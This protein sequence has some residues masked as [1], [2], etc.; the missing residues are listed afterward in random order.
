MSAHGFQLEEIH[1]QRP[2]EREYSNALDPQLIHFEWLHRD[3]PRPRDD[4]LPNGLCWR[5]TAAEEQY[6]NGT[7]TRSHAHSSEFR[8]TSRYLHGHPRSGVATLKRCMPLDFCV[9]AGMP[10][11]R[12]TPRGCLP[13]KRLS[14][15]N[16]DNGVPS[17]GSGAQP[18]EL[19]RACGSANRGSA[20]CVCPSRSA[21]PRRQEICGAWEQAR[22]VCSSRALDRV[23]TCRDEP[24]S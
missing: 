24:S 4:R 18:V 19:A 11:N 17:D 7:A 3:L 15:V 13:R 5:R 12:L 2:N 8:S 20:F 14:L 10:G 9:S 6:V 1:K 23:P 16:S 21:S 22:R